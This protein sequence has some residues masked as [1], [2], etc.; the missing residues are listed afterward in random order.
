MGTEK[1]KVYRETVIV[2]TSTEK[3]ADSIKI[4]FD[5]LRIFALIEKDP[6]IKEY[7]FAG[8]KVAAFQ[9]FVKGLLIAGITDQ[10]ELLNL[11]SRKVFPG[12]DKCIPDPKTETDIKE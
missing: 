2:E 4:K 3:K 6:K 11:A 10:T 1:E 12:I 8:W 5:K 7:L 9:K